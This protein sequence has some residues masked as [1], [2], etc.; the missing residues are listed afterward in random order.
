MEARGLPR[1]AVT[2]VSPANLNAVLGDV[3]ARAVTED[4]KYVRA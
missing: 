1:L 4:R 2:S 3:L